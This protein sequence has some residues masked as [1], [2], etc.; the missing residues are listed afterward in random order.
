M[1]RESTAF[2][3]LGWISASTSRTWNTLL[4]Q[5]L[6][7]QRRIGSFDVKIVED[8][9]MD[10]GTIFFVD[11]RKFHPVLLCKVVNVGS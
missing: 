6:K 11:E 10:R 2:R 1:A 7:E 9:R 3:P 5:V 4:K 8:P